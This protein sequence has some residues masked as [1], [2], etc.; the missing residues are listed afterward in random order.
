MRPFAFGVAP[1]SVFL[2]GALQGELAHAGGDAGAFAQLE[3]RQDQQVLARGKTHADVVVAAV[4]RVDQGHRR[5]RRMAA[6]GWGFA[7]P[8][9]AGS[10]C[11]AWAV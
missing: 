11:E 2:L 4:V 5:L 8:P 3:G 6:G 7:P 1:C 10:E 9:G